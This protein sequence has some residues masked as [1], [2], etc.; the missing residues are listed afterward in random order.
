M[1][2][3]AGLLPRVRAFAN[4][5]TDVMQVPHWVESP[6]MFWIT[7]DQRLLEQPE[8]LAGAAGHI[9]KHFP[10]QDRTLVNGEL[11][12]KRREVEQHIQPLPRPLPW[13]IVRQERRAGLVDIE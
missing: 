11:P 10:M 8:G 6:S 3:H 1:H 13:W 5:V 9:S 12:E 7:R 2:P 4:R